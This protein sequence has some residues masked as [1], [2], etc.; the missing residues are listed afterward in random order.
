M[1]RTRTLV[2]AVSVVLGVSTAARS[3]DAQEVPQ[4][5]ASPPAAEQA[6]AAPA[7]P[8]DAPIAP[9]APIT[10]TPPT[11]AGPAEAAPAPAVDPA[12]AKPSNRVPYGDRE[13]HPD[14]DDFMG[15]PLHGFSSVQFAL[16]DQKKAI[17]R[18]GYAHGFQLDNVVLYLAPDLGDRV[19]FLTEIVLEP[20]FDDQ[21]IGIDTERLQIGYV[22]DNHLTATAG[23]FHTPLGYHITA[24]HHG[25]HMMTAVEKP[26]YLQFEDH[27]GVLPVHTTGLWL[28]GQTLL[29]ASR[30][31]YMAWF[32]NGDTLSSDGAVT[33]LDMNMFH[34]DNRDWTLGARLNLSIGGALEGLVVGASAMTQRI[35]YAPDPVATPAINVKVPFR[36]RLRVGA[37]HV[38]YDGHGVE[39]ANEIHA[40]D[41]TTSFDDGVTP[42]RTVKSWAGYSQLAYWIGGVFAPY[43]RVERADFDQQD[44]F[45]AA[46][47]NGLGYTKVAAGARFNVSEKLAV[48]VEGS[49]KE[50]D[51]ESA[52]V[53]GGNI[54][55]IRTQVAVRF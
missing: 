12:T 35:D 37:L 1:R 52:T 21:A 5:P 42:N 4:A 10:I 6:P 18:R 54:N 2:A 45:F 36:S 39:W 3:A 22:F 48:K 51:G 27:K 19:R 47:T 23:R 46:Q 15:V 7:A 24:F 26:E 50:I 29:G 43:V 30:L 44:G 34:D 9:P 14:S 17:R 40:F 53:T 28:T 20:G 41:N 25:A 32:G 49:R 33:A 8:T 55:V 16:D 11:A 13:Q 31:G 38:V